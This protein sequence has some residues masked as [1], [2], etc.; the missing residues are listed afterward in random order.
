MVGTNLAPMIG[1]V[2]CNFIK[3]QICENITTFSEIQKYRYVG[4]IKG[5]RTAK[6][7]KGGVQS[8]GN[9]TCSFTLKRCHIQMSYTDFF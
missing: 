3:L 5:F 7:L 2:I 9:N 4:G 6:K 1:R 8:H